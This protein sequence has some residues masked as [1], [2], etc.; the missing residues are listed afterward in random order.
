MSLSN[1]GPMNGSIL[2]SGLMDFLLTIS[3]TKSIRRSSNVVVSEINEVFVP[4]LRELI[5][6][7]CRTLGNKTAARIT[8]VATGTVRRVCEL[9]HSSS[10][11]FQVYKCQS[12]FP[13]TTNPAA[14]MLASPAIKCYHGEPLLL[15]L[16]GS[17]SARLRRLPMQSPHTWEHHLIT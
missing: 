12:E 2:Q 4:A 9:F 11:T 8:V 10:D 3:P 17:L 14:K 6:L 5:R 1:R 7:T 13:H 15:G 16:V